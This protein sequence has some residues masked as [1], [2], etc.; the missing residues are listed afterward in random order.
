MN[1]ENNLLIHFPPAHKPVGATLL[2]TV[3]RRH[4]RFRIE[5][6][7]SISRYDQYDGRRRRRCF[8]IAA[9]GASQRFHVDDEAIAHIAFDRPL[10]G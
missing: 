5:P 2:L 1:V 10:V 3:D 8:G 6:P 7:S 9:A 4:A